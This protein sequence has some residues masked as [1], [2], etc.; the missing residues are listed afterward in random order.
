LHRSHPL[1]HPSAAL[2]PSVRCLGTTA[3]LRDDGGGGG[4]RV[5]VEKRWREF[6][7]DPSQWWDNR[8]EKVITTLLLGNSLFYAVQ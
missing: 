1:F 2:L 4:Q 3:T 6:F 8:V 7:T 5:M